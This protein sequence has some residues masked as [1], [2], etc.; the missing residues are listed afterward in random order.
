M[1]VAG[2]AARLGLVLAALAASALASACGER[3]TPPPQPLTKAQ[4]IERIQQI[5]R[6]LGV[7]FARRPP[8]GSLRM[9]VVGELRQLRDGSAEFSERLSRL[10]PPASAKTPHGLWV[11]GLDDL[12]R[13]VEP[14]I[15][16]I[17][18]RK[19]AE[20]RAALREFRRSG[21]RA[22]LRR[23]QR[24]FTAAGYPIRTQPRL[25]PALRSVASRRGRR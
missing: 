7:R 12:A 9:R 23:A 21:A 3:T 6:E 24:M 10:D 19:A 1:L 14:L 17:E 5:R 18:S 20:T 4:Y 2:R 11:D 16:A 22:K 15:P 8:Q 13:G 25:P